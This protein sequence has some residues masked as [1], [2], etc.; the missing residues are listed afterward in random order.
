M[1]GERHFRIELPA[2]PA[3]RAIGSAWLVLPSDFPLVIARIRLSRDAVLRIPHVEPNGQLCFDGDPGPQSGLNQQ[4]RIEHT[5]WQFQEAF[6]TPWQ[7]GDLDADFEKET[8]NYWDIYVGRHQSK[9]DPVRRV[10]TVA[11]APSRP[12][13][14]EG[15][16]VMPGRTLVV[17]DDDALTTRLI[18]SWGAGSKVLRADI[19]E[20]PIGFP[21]SPMTWPASLGEIE[22]LL[23]Q[24]MAPKLLRKFFADSSRHRVVIFHAPQCSY[25]YLLPGGPA[26]VVKAGYSQKAFRNTKSIPLSVER[27]DPHWTYGR[28]QIPA[29]RQR[30]EQRVVVFGGGALGSLVIDQLARAGVGR[31]TV[32]DPQV[33][34][35]SNIG[36][37]LLGA[38]FLDLSKAKSIARRVGISN[39]ACQVESFAGR[40]ETWLSK[41]DVQRFDMFVDLTGEPEVRFALENVRKRV[42]LPLVVG[43]MEPFVAAAHV[44]C[45]PAGA[46]WLSSDE[47]PLLRLQAVSWPD[48]VIRLEPGCTSEFQAYTPAQACYAVALVSEAIIDF[49][50]SGAGG[51]HIRSWVRGQ[52]YLDKCH[53]NL[54]LADWATSATNVDGMIIERGWHG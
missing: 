11:A 37:H 15:T 52:K 4:E 2:L 44:C 53:P 12:V 51:G 32:V 8:R 45:L 35:S 46:R 5:L 14:T 29:V 10:Y 49:L 24:W 17:G 13:L 28:D 54:G 30:C 1:R 48:E 16:I 6:L 36:R 38:E 25:A 42:H 50:D 33:F 34:A 18:A 19:A 9:V 31:I 21:W 39:P 40:A 3:E 47:D 27:I 41:N 20:V 23:N 43:W 7:R 26:S 22:F